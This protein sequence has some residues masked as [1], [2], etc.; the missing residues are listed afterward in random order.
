MGVVHLALAQ[1][2]VGFE[3]LVALKLLDPKFRGDPMRSESLLRE[4]LVGGRLDHEHLVQIFDL[5]QEMDQYFIAMEYVRGFSLSHVLAHLRRTGRQ[6]PIYLAVRI[7]RA[8]TDALVYMHG[9]TFGNDQ[10]LG[11]VHGDISPSNILLGADGRMKLSDLGVVALS[12]EVR[13]HIAGKTA[14][15]PPEAF[16]GLPRTQIWDVYALGA[17]LYEALGGVRMTAGDAALDDTEPV[18]QRPGTLADLRPD[19]PPELLAVVDR[20]TARDPAHRIRHATG[21]AEALDAALPETPGERDRQRSFLTALFAEADFVRDHGELPSE[22]G[23]PSDIVPKVTEEETEQVTVRGLRGER[24]LRLG[25]SPAHGSQRARQSGERVAQELSRRLSRPVR[26]VVLGDY[27]ALVD[28]LI[29][30]DLDLAWMPPLALV[31]ALDRGAGVLAVA[32]R[33]GATAYNAAVIV[34]TDSPLR[35][36]EDVGAA[37]AAFVDQRSA[38]GY[39]FAVAGM[40]LALGAE[41]VRALKPHFHGSH[42]AVCEAVAN[43]WV[44]IGATYAVV[45]GEGEVTKAAWPELLPDRAAEIRALWMSGPIPSDCM[46]HRPH[47]PERVATAVRDALL[48]LA[49]EPEGAELLR[50]VFGA[51]TFV[52]GGPD[53]YESA[54]VARD[55]VT[56]VLTASS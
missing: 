25:I 30:S 35:R 1:G 40:V 56:K 21:L 10:P 7:V 51:E 16:R 47:L 34:H 2:P 41:R 50:D 20:V 28:S 8:M 14:Y 22:S 48:G 46:A 4:A 33:A 42:R 38:S 11:L 5:G 17:V 3:K 49:G 55:L 12:G 6:L 23:V 27:E 45:R 9:L 43:R 31:G 19:C 36:L 24:A 18:T 39:V 52:R 53:D 29:A 54:R 15:F 44:D 26:T 13:S 32:S 37:T